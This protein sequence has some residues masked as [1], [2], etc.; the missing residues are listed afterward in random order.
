MASQYQSFPDA[1]GA[2]QSVD[3]LRALALPDL[4][5]KRFLDVGCNEGFF[6]AIARAAGASTVVGLDTQ[7]AVL[8]RARVRFPDVEFREQSWDAPI[9]GSYDVILFSS[10]IH[11][12]KDQPAL[13]AKL[14][15]LL[16]PEGV[17][18]LELGITEQPGDQYLDVPRHH[19]PPCAFAT[20]DALRRVL[21]N[22]DVREIGPSVMQRGDPVPRHVLHIRTRRVPGPVPE[23]PV[24][25]LLDAP[26]RSGKSYLVRNLVAGATERCG[27]LS[28]DGLLARIDAE[29]AT[30]HPA[31][32]AVLD[33]IAAFRSGESARSDLVM[34]MLAAEGLLEDFLGYVETIAAPASRPITL[35]D[36]FLPAAARET[37]RL[38]FERRGFRVWNTLPQ[39]RF[40]IE[41]V[42]SRTLTA[43]KPELQRVAV[44]ERLQHLQLP[45]L[46]EKTLLHL[47]RGGNADFLDLVREAGALRAVDTLA[48][49]DEADIV[50]S[51]TGTRDP[52]TLL[53]HC[54]ETL[55]R[56]ARGGTLVLAL[57]RRGADGLPT[58]RIAAALRTGL[59]GHVIRKVTNAHTRRDPDSARVIH[60]ERAR[61]LAVLVDDAGSGEAAALINAFGGADIARIP[62]PAL[63]AALEAGDS[64][65]DT[66]LL[67]CDGAL[68]PTRRNALLDQLIATGW[69]TWECRHRHPREYRALDVDTT[70]TRAFPPITEQ[71]ASAARVRND[72]P[73]TG[74][75]TL[76]L[77]R[78]WRRA[79]RGVL[80]R[81]RTGGKRVITRA[82]G[83]RIQGELLKAEFD[84]SELRLGGW[85]VDLERLTG[86]RDFVI[87]IDGKPAGNARGAWRRRPEINSR[88][89][90]PEERHAGFF[91]RIPAAT[92]GGA[93][94]LRTLASG[95]GRHGRWIRIGWR[96]KRKGDVRWL[97]Y[98]A[99]FRVLRPR[100]P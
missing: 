33:R 82:R 86:I 15:S 97:P 34:Q 85:A 23:A 93:K 72:A 19:G 95:E 43:G 18:V 92:A 54:E 61:P 9:A 60:V 12:A 2:S 22:Y 35:W 52:Q 13:I 50:V 28:V 5:G 24:L 73:A 46:D 96:D 3:K 100:K 65:P 21:A 30:Q 58:D 25:V 17:L 90:L 11:Y 45:A 89:G 32:A 40:A 39:L 48:E 67:L 59:P 16:A 80:Q 27:Q 37:V 79:V 31:H 69:S 68:P 71:P 38:Y 84:G 26:S 44:R 10:A 83:D 77:W 53:A 42:D 62:T 98:G 57:P 4:S 41:R 76:P 1:R 81:F 75:A 51:E 49:E 20:P 55:P 87:E 14:V 91:L 78:R 6:C 70:L 29:S 74:E 88:F 64:L 8:A 56:L 99:R 36:G 66:P 47:G 94:R 7:T 63:T